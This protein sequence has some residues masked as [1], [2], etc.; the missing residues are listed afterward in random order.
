MERFLGPL[1]ERS[2]HS[3]LD[4]HFE[5]LDVSQLKLSLFRGDVVLTNL[6]LRPEAI[7]VPGIPIAVKRGFVRELRI[8]VPWL[9]LASEPIEIL[10]DTVELVAS[11]QPDEPPHARSAT[12]DGAVEPKSASPAL[13]T[14]PTQSPLASTAPAPASSGGDSWVQSLV[15]RAL[16]NAALTLR[17]VVVKFIEGRA[18][19]S[20]S[21]RSLTLHSAGAQWQRAFVELDGASKT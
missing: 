2:L 11:L 15:Q 6:V 7:R 13:P 18:V 10:I 17:N 1:L 4:R 5:N 16:L 20:L 14:S 19:A 3:V 9:K 12:V 21:L 8:R